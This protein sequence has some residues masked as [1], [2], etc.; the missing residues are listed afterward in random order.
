[1]SGSLS[2]H[3]LVV[4]DERYARKRIVELLEERDAVEHITCA[5]SGTAAIE[6][7]QSNDPDVV[8]LD[9]QMPERTGIDVIDTIGP[10]EM[11]TTIFVTAYDQYTLDAFERAALD[12]LLKPFD[13]DRFD[14]AFC[15]AV[16]TIRHKKANAL[17]ERL[18]HLLDASER[19][20]SP[21]PKDPIPSSDAQS[22]SGAS[23]S[24]LERVTV[25]LPGKVRVIP[26]E[27]IRYITAEDSYVRLHT[28]ENSYL[29][30]ERMHVLEERLNP[31]DFVRIHRST[32]VRI[33]LVETVLR[34]SGGDY[35]VRLTDRSELD[36]SRSRYEALIQ[37]LQ[38]GIS[39]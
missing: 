8:F 24:Y 20:H 15:R 3:A 21:D 7:L 35:S 16:E 9:V 19:A 4:D 32:I 38:T 34:K 33:D 31:A 29:V 11:P 17:T 36:V 28:K 13:N 12:Y 23:S 30:R 5:D 39:G 22:S 37:R 27:N 25:E 10:S 18:E 26:V 2:L 1:M 6:H 14:Q